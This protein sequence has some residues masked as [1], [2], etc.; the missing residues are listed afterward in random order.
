MIQVYVIKRNDGK[1]YEGNT[2]WWSPRITDAHIYSSGRRVDVGF[3]NVMEEIRK[4]TPQYTA[5]I[6]TLN[7]VEA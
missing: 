2:Q 4:L 7:C 5:E 3:S 1:Y 6:I